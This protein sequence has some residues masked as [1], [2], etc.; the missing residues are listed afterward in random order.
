MSGYNSLR[1]MGLQFVFRKHQVQEDLI[2]CT[3][4]GL[5]ISSYFFSICFYSWSS[6]KK[7][8]LALPT[9]S[10]AAKAISWLT[11][12]NTASIPTNF[13]CKT[14]VQSWHPITDASL[15]STGQPQVSLLENKK[16]LGTA[17]ENP[18]WS[19]R[20]LRHSWHI[21]TGLGKSF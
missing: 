1:I 18:F 17:I 16:C 9:K 2:S 6:I 13:V 11:F 14:T 5:I 19:T 4:L 10:K 15:S 8:Y 7:N 21:Q 12:W 3:R 20:S